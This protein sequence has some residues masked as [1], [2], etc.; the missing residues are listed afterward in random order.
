M[1]KKKSVMVEMTNN[2]SSSLNINEYIPR[3]DDYDRDLEDWAELPPGYVSTSKHVSSKKRK[4]II[5]VEGEEEEEQPEWSEE[6]FIYENSE[7]T[8]SDKSSTSDTDF[9]AVTEDV[10]ATNEEDYDLADVFSSLE[11]SPNP[12]SLL[13]LKKYALDLDWSEFPNAF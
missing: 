7:G 13:L 1:G 9:V 5:T 11:F 12:Y 3:P 6:G 10:D 2:S 8:K 4:R